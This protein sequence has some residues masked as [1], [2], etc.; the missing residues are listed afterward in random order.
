SLLFIAPM[1]LFVVGISGEGSGECSG[2][3]RM[4]WKSRERWFFYKIEFVIELEF[5]HWN[6][7]RFIG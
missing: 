7:E 3:G 6:N 5:F 1:V 2:S 4:D